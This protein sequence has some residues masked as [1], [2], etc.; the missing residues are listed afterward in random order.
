MNN[1]KIVDEDYETNENELIN[2]EY[3]KQESAV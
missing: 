2:R 3:F 1:D